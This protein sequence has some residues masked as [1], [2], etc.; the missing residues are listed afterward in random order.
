MQHSHNP[1]QHTDRSELMLELCIALLRWLDAQPPR[2]PFD[3]SADKMLAAAWSGGGGSGS[4]RQ[5]TKGARL[6]STEPIIALGALEGSVFSRLRLSTPARQRP[7]HLVAAGAMLASSTACSC[8]SA[9]R[10][11]VVARSAASP[12]ALPRALPSGARRQA[13]AAQRSALLQ[14]QRRSVAARGER[15]AGRTGGQGWRRHGG[16]AAAYWASY[17]LSLPAL[18]CLTRCAL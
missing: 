17:Q 1:A 12:P 4:A 7:T 6:C 13:G 3:Q 5:I 15:G 8:A 10:Q 16:A 9:G 11:P 18:A 2:I 14:Q